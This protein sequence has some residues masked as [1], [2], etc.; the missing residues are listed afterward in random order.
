MYRRFVARGDQLKVFVE[1]PAYQYVHRGMLE[2]TPDWQ[3][4]LQWIR[5]AGDEGVIIF[6][7]AD[8]GGLH[9][10]LRNDRFNVIGGSQLGDRMESDR[11]FGQQIFRSMGLQTASS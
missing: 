2:L 7:C 3:Q 4:E 6:E 8:K 9:D 11:E 1:N 10:T 5:D